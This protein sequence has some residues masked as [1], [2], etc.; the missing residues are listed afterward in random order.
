MQKY[1]LILTSSA[2]ML[3]GSAL[4]AIAQQSEI[5]SMAEQLAQTEYSP[6]SKEEPG[7]MMGHDRMARFHMMGH[8]GMMGGVGMRI[9]FALMDSDSDGTISLQEFEAAHER[10]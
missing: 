2:A 6:G 3:A 1:L 8:H 10:I 4:A 5:P 7:G 9:I